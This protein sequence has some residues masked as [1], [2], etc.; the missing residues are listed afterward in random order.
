MISLAGRIVADPQ[1]RGDVEASLMGRI[2]PPEGGLPV[3]GQTVHAGDISPISRRRWG[4]WIA[5]RCAA[6]WRS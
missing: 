2:E 3:L 1:N 5:R 6:R 4:W